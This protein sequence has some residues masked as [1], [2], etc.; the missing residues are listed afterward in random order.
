MIFKYTVE[1]VEGNT[2]LYAK[3]RIMVELDDGEPLIPRFL[4]RGMHVDLEIRC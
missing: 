2:K 3:A 4:L 1:P